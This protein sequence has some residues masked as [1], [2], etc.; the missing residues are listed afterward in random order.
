LLGDHARRILQPGV[1]AV[2]ALDLRNGADGQCIDEPTIRQVVRRR[3]AAVKSHSVEG[4][5]GRDDRRARPRLAG[6][7]PIGAQNRFDR[8]G[9]RKRP[10]CEDERCAEKDRLGD[11]RA[12]II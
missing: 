12:K 6:G 1:V 11:R 5:G 10:A 3:V 4:I 8:I 7:R 2:E 9:L